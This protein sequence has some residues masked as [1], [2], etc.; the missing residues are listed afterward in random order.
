MR[1]DG[2]K[3]DAINVCLKESEDEFI[4]ELIYECNFKERGINKY[5]QVG[6]NDCGKRYFSSYII[7]F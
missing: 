3:E 6:L 2:T 5:Y 7:S 1:F 4:F